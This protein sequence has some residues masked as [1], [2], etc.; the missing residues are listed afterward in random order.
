MSEIIKKLE[1]VEEKKIDAIKKAHLSLVPPQIHRPTTTHK[2]FPSTLA[3]ALFFMAAVSTWGGYRWYQKRATLQTTLEPKVELNFNQSNNEAILAFRQKNYQL[4]LQ[5][6]TPLVN[7][8]LE[9]T[10]KEILNNMAVIY[11]HNNDFNK[12]LPLI[13]LALKKHSNDATLFNN[14]GT[15]YLAQEKLDLAIVDFLAAIRINPDYSDAMLNLGFAYE[16]QKE[17]DLSYDFYRRYIKARD[18]SPEIIKLLKQRIIKM[19]PLL[20]YSAGAVK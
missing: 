13:D 11:R 7:S 3:I 14:R 8:D 15:V 10:P 19:Y 6:I 20:L 9:K 18:A 1:G 12:A 5:K 2:K 16:K 17:W 4:A